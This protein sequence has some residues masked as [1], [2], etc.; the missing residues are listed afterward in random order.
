MGCWPPHSCQTYYREPRSRPAGSW[1]CGKCSGNRLQNWRTQ[2]TWPVRRSSEG[3]LGLSRSWSTRKLFKF[4]ILF[5]CVILFLY[6]MHIF[7]RIYLLLIPNEIHHVYKTTSIRAI[8]L[9]LLQ[10]HIIIKI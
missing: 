1:P 10:G 9:L 8:H 4:C 5:E 6:T 3:G 7:C 2:T